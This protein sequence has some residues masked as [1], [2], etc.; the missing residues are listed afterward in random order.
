MKL[1]LRQMGWVRWEYCTISPVYITWQEEVL[2]VAD[3]A[4]YEKIK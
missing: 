3:M 4:S 1:T 2:T